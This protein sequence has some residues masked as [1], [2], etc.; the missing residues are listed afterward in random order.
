MEHST[1]IKNQ[2]MKNT[3]TLAIDPGANGGFAWRDSDNIVHT[4]PMPDTEGDVLNLLR[5]LRA[6]GVDSIT[7]EDQVGC[8]GPG[9]KV[10]ATAMFTF[11]RGFGFI[12]G[13]SQALGFKIHAVRPMKWQKSHS[14]GTKKDAGGTTPWKNKL[15]AVA[16]RLFPHADVTLKTADALLILDYSDRQPAP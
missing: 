4:Q 12:L 9:M 8:V 7:I 1:Q 6:Q 15:K 13:A 14:L 3:N 2:P 5:T 10:A 16:Q 11:G